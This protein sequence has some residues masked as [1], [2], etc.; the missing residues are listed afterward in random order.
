MTFPTRAHAPT[1]HDWGR[2]LELFL[3]HWD[4][5]PRVAVV[6]HY[7]SGDD[8]VVRWR[9]S[10]AT[11]H[12]VVHI[13]HDGVG[14][15]GESYTPSTFVSRTR[16]DCRENRQQDTTVVRSTDDNY[17]VWLIPSVLQGDGT[18]FID[19]DGGGAE[20]ADLMAMLAVGSRV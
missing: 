3:S 7:R 1:G 14:G 19:Y 4:E 11:E 12:V 5:Q 20:V 17:T 13:Q 15:G 16:V 8:V 2:F 6:G 9:A 10:R 18:T